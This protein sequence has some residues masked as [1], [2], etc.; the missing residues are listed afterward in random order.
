MSV[1]AAESTVRG[2]RC[3]CL[4]SPSNPWSRSWIRYRGVSGHGNAS[5]TC[6]A[7]Q[8]AVGCAVT[9]HM[10]DAAPIVGE[11]TSRNVTVGTTK[12]SAVVPQGQD[13]EL[14][15]GARTCQRSQGHEE[16][17]ECRDHGGERFHR[18]PLPSTAAV[19]TEFLVGTAS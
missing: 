19:R 13:F 4:V 9:A 6:C 12:K 5:R 17:V 10:P 3:W 14:E 8:A 16:R 18:R 15:R 11:H 2:G 1:D 7:V